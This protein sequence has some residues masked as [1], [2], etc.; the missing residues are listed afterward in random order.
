MFVIENTRYGDLVPMLGFH[1][2]IL[3]YHNA[4]F[5]IRAIEIGSRVERLSLGRG[6]VREECH[7]L[8]PISFERY[9]ALTAGPIF[10]EYVVT[11]VTG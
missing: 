11:K 3:L 4:C 5:D 7:V 6:S 10:I 2:C 8:N 9:P 1:M